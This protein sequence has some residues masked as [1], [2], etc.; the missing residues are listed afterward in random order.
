MWQEKE[1]SALMAVASGDNPKVADR[2]IY[3]IITVTLT[4]TISKGPSYSFRTP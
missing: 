1:Q 3:I 2:F 4:L